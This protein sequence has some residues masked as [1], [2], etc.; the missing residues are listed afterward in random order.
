M[1]TVLSLKFEKDLVNK[2]MEYIYSLECN[3]MYSNY[4]TLSCKKHP[5]LQ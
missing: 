3:W 1:C 2:E 5:I 4:N